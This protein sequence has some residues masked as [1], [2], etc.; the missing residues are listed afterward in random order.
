MMLVVLMRHGKAEG[1][2]PGLRDEERRLT[3]EGRRGVE[4]VARLLPLEGRPLVLHS[5]LRRA[6]ETAEI[7]ARIVG[8]EALQE[9]RLHP[10]D[11]GPDALQEILEEQW[12]RGSLVLVG[13]NPSM[14]EAVAS[15]VGGSIVMEP[16]AAAVV[17]A[18]APTPGGG[19][20]VALITPAAALRCS[21]GRKA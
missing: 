4:A 16:G 1:K 14:E 21:G 7:V 20:L 13:H 17:R 2:R 15:L 19:E 11:F 18:Q 12:G 10:D 8:G 6:V 5:P 3:G 9:P